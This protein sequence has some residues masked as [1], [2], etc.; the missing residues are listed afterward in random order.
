MSNKDFKQYGKDFLLNQEIWSMTDRLEL[1][2]QKVFKNKKTYPATAAQKMLILY[3]LG[4]LDKILSTQNEISHAKQA[5]LLSLV[6]S[7]SDEN[8]RHYLSFINLPESE[9][10][11][12]SNYEYL[13]QTFEEQGLNKIAQD[14]E[15]ILKS[16]QNKKD[17]RKTK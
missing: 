12:E 11:T 8:I 3:H 1:L 9:I 10:K 17:K 16:I 4:L 7:A 2:E 14:C 5:K 13:V 6:I 15:E